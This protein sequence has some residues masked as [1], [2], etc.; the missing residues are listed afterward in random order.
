MPCC[1]PARALIAAHRAWRID[2]VGQAGMQRRHVPRAVERPDMHVVDLA[3]AADMGGEIA[4][5]AVAVEIAR[6]RLR[7]GHGR[8]SRISDQALRRISTETS[9]DRIGSI[10][11]QPVARMTSAATIAAGRAE[12][13]AQHMQDRAAHVQAVAV[14]A[15]QHDRSRRC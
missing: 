14:A 9:T 15:M 2:A 3:H 4:C 7:A 5:D 11:V 13:V 10:G 6:G 8:T 12:Q 1:S